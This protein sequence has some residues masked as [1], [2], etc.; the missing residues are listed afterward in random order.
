MAI[1]MKCP[2]CGKRAFDTSRL[3]NTK[4]PVEISLKCPHCRNIV[5][6]PITER[7]CLPS[8]LGG[9]LTQN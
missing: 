9:N 5:S 1:S 8:R 4:E 7:M 6:V 2:L 3:H